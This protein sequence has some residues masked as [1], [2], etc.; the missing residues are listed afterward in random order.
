M[1]NINPTNLIPNEFYK[2]AAEICDRLPDIHFADI[3]RVLYE[4][5]MYLRHNLTLVDA[6]TGNH[7]E[8]IKNILG[9]DDDP[10]KFTEI[11]STK[12]LEPLKRRGRPRRREITFADGKT[13]AYPNQLDMLRMN[14]IE[15]VD[16]FPHNCPKDGDYCELEA[17]KVN[18]LFEKNEQP[19]IKYVCYDFD[20][21]KRVFVFPKE[22]EAVNA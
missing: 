1:P 13:Y 17:I 16:V 7:V 21:K 4:Q 9:L 3:A 15:D 8:N 10:E 14:G 5:D 11:R 12:K 18:D 2:Q 19:I 22:S 20:G 6:Q